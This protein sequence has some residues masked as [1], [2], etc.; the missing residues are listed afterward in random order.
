MISQIFSRADGIAWDAWTPALGVS[1]TVLWAVSL[2]LCRSG[3]HRGWR[4]YPKSLLFWAWFGFGLA[5]VVRFW[6]VSFDSVT[7]GDLSGR[8]AGLSPDTINDALVA[9]ILFWVALCIGHVAAR[10]TR[11]NPLAVTDRL[12]SLEAIRLYDAV[13]VLAPAAMILQ[14][15]L[16]IEVPSALVRP[17]GLAAS[18]WTC[19][20]T[21]A[22]FTSGAVEVPSLRMRRWFYLVPGLIAFLIE[23][24][25]ERLLIIIMIPIIAWLFLGRHVRL[26][27][28]VGL[29]LLV[30]VGGTIAAGTYRAMRWDGQ[31]FA[32]ASE[33]IDPASW[34]ADPYA[35]PW[36]ALL[37]RFHSFDSLVFF[38]YL[39][40]DLIPFEERNPITD[41]V[42]E[43]LL[44]RALY[45]DKRESSRAALF[46]TQYWSY[47]DGTRE[48]AN[49]APS[50]AGDLY[51]AGGL[52]WV[53]G[54][55]A[56]FGLLIGILDRW[57]RRLSPGAQAIL[58]TYLALQVAGGIERDF[59]RATATIVQAVI[60][61]VFAAAV[62]SR[63]L[64]SARSSTLSLLRW[65]SAERPR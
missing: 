11:I 60:A 33:D 13:A 44:P 48:E 51:S 34:L 15:G 6:V 7:Y 14:G 22:W 4:H 43:G 35:A 25:R 18:L 45:P 61:L 62:G 26:L 56:A 47:D 23:P 53:L 59:S 55:A 1:L 20:A 54:G 9:T 39:V 36:G 21:A 24:Y 29:L 12:V 49:I 32:Q 16:W 28:A 3:E 63:L 17:L 5:F 41:A 64:G 50:M 65:R 30:A 2:R 58:I 57:I 38:V 42:V 27:S 19:A 52:G 37:R 10:P 31:S 40:P 8:L 46:S